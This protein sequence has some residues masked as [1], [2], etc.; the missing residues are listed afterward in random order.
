MSQLSPGT[1][2]LL[3][4]G[5]LAAMH[6]ALRPTAPT[7]WTMCDPTVD[8]ATRGSIVENLTNTV[9]DLWQ[10]RGS[11]YITPNRFESPSLLYDGS[12]GPPPSFLTKV[13]GGSSFK[14]DT[15]IPFVKDDGTVGT[16]KRSCT[17]YHDGEP[18]RLS[19]VMLP[20]R[21]GKVGAAIP[22]SPDIFGSGRIS[23][24]SSSTQIENHVRDGRVRVR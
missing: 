11:I 4:L 16:Y 23:C 7:H 14:F 20:S 9:R 2:R 24:S 18:T 10:P 8:R 19:Q 22:V 15:E 1:K 5:G 13:R 12:D 6:F 17:V 21:Y 3:A